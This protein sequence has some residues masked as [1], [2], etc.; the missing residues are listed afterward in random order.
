M[1]NSLPFHP[2]PLISNGSEVAAAIENAYHNLR[3]TFS[4]RSR[5]NSSAVAGV[6][7]VDSNHSLRKTVIPQTG[8]T[9]LRL[10]VVGTRAC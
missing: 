8:K 2:K 9:R 7:T 5:I 10:N 6:V 1:E 4:I 3:T